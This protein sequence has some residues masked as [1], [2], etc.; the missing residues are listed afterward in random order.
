MAERQ[1]RM[2]AELAEL[3]LEAARILQ[4]RLAEAQTPAEA[5]D[6]GLTFQ[7]VSRSLRQTLM[8]EMRLEKDRRALARE[9]ADDAAKAREAEAKAREAE[10][11]VRRFKVR[12]AVSRMILD[13]YES[14][15]DAEPLLDELEECLDAYV[16]GHDAAPLEALVETLARDLGLEL[17]AADGDDPA[18]HDGDEVAAEAAPAP[19]G[20]PPPLIQTPDFGWAAAPDS[21]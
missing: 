14:E 1:G 19:E 12:H 3:T 7:R 20:R 17:D 15:E 4:G 10:V 13:A 2:L 16:R 18:D 6:L 5:R 8:L 9:A 21:S 11:Q